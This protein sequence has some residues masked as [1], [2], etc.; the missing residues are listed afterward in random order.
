MQS[1]IPPV[2]RKAIM[3]ELTADKFVRYTNNSDNKLYVITAHDSPYIMQEIGRLREISFRAAG[4]GTGKSV[5][6]DDFDTSAKPYKQLIVWD[7]KAKEILGGYRYIYTGNV[8]THDLS[9]SEIFSFSE[10]F[11]DKYLPRTIELGRSF[12]QPNYQSMQLR[13]KGLY[14]LDNLWDGLG[15][16]VLRYPEVN[17]FFGK[18]TMYVSYNIEA[19]N[20][21]LYFLRKHFADS[22]NLVAPLHPL[23]TNTDEERMKRLFTGENYKD[24]YAILQREV[25]ALGENIPPLINSYMKLSPSMRVFGTAIN[26]FFGDVE[27]TGILINISD[28]YAEKIER[29]TAPM[30]RIAQRLRTRWWIQR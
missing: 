14:A 16:L 23:Q 7:P 8:S 10:K 4:G 30:H 6:I 13:S 11:M 28:I 26:P 17:Y 19:R 24:D 9:T 15:A 25:R 1:V 29:Y 20:V 27:E 18:V 12:V 5:D 2:E 22:D 21:L 3:H